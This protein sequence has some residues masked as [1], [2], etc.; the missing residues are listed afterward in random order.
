MATLIIDT[1][2]L[3]SAVN[4]N[5]V[6][7][8]IDGI[9]K[10]DANWSDNNTYSVNEGEH[11]IKVVQKIWGILPVYTGSSEII[12]RLQKNETVKLKYKK[13]FLSYNLEIDS[14]FLK[15]SSTKIPVVIE[16]NFNETQY[17]IEDDPNAY[18]TLTQIKTKLE[19]QE[20]NLNT[21]IKVVGAKEDYAEVKQFPEIN[22]Q[23]NSFI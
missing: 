14:R 23:F 13:G 22:T 3:L 19:K 20:I 18:Y 8:I 10:E 5:K 17:L 21:R 16:E 7:I 6:L 2:H 9:A 4:T 12:V 1:T 15:P 11:H